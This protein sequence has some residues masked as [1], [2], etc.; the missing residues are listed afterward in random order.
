MESGSGEGFPVNPCIPD[1]YTAANRDGCRANGCNAF[2]PGWGGDI[3]DSMVQEA[4]SNRGQNGFKQGYGTPCV[5][6]DLSTSAPRDLTKMVVVGD[7]GFDTESMYTEAYAYPDRRI[8][9]NMILE[10]D[11]TGHGN[12]GH[13]DEDC[14]NPDTAD[15]CTPLAACFGGD[16][17]IV[18]EV[19][20][21][22]Q[23]ARHMG[24]D[25]LGFADGHAKWMDAETILLGGS[26]HTRNGIHPQVYYGLCVCINL[27]TKSRWD[28]PE[29]NDP[30]AGTY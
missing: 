8:P 3:T 16:T 19:A 7:A 13:C 26:D 25:N 29:W 9:H 15:A 17:R 18:T 27:T 1:W 12:R 2:P 6:R 20:Y 28:L 22:K 24:G 21:R 5:L 10:G 23:F 4:C 14:G 30:S 11:C